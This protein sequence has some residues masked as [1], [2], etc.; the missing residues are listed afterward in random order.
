MAISQYNKQE[1]LNI[2]SI[3]YGNVEW[4]NIINPTNREIEYLA[5]QYHFHQ[6]DLDDCLSRVQRPKVDTY[7]GYLFWVLHFPVYNKVKRI[8]THAQISV[9][10]ANGYII[11]LHDGEIKPLLQLF[12]ECKGNE[13]SLR[14]N[15]ANGSAYLFYKILDKAVDAYFPVLDKILSLIDETED[16]AFDENVEVAQEVSVL[17]R[18]IIR[19]RRIIFPMRTVM[20][21][22]DIKLKRFTGI[23]MSVY[24]GDL[25]DHVNKQC[26]TLDECKEVIE[27]FKDADYILT[28]ERINRVI[29]ILTIISAVSLPFVALA[30]IYGMNIVLPGGLEKGSLLTFVLVLLT[31][32]LISSGMLYLFHHKRWI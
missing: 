8:A 10:I 1:Q 3:T 6:L 23:D 5:Q 32:L 17:R 25:L 9:F 26:E 11:T 12:Q 28:T 22:M 30:S 31:M 15:F 13:E 18:D 27:V 14:N 7:E 16:L 24:I 19:Q 29:R 21:E 2:E 20:S 4:V